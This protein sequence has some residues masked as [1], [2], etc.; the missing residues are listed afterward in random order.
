MVNF[1]NSDENK[2]INLKSRRLR[3]KYKNFFNFLNKLS[4]I[5]FKGMKRKEK[6]KTIYK[7][8]VNH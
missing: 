8:T 3:K 4:T 7:D 6:N 1:K 2:V 5:F